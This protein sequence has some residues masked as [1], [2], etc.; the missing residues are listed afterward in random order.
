MVFG[1]MCWQPTWPSTI[2]ASPA[3]RKTSFRNTA[4]SN[5]TAATSSLFPVCADLLETR[6]T[7][8]HWEINRDLPCGFLAECLTVVNSIKLAVDIQVCRRRSDKLDVH[9][10]VV[11]T[12]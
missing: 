9:R 6:T 8:S 10:H 1:P 4:D 7:R 3:A 12:E 5:E 2:A 11:T